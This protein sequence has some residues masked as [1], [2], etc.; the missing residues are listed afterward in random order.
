M[1]LTHVLAPFDLEAASRPALEYAADLVGPEG[2]V[3]IVHVMTGLSIET[4]TAL[5]ETRPL[6][7]D[8]EERARAAI[9]EA[10]EGMS[11]RATFESAVVFGDPV[12]EI[13]RAARDH[14]AEAVVIELKNRSRLGKLLMGSKVQSILLQTHCPVICVPRD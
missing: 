5:H 6:E 13:L 4:P 8:A 7:H 9:G 1:P 11:G 10:I 3:T 2:T 14:E 12:G